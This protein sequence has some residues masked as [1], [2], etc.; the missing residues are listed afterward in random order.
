MD[1][2]INRAAIRYADVDEAVAVAHIRIVVNG[3][4]GS[5]LDEVIEPAAVRVSGRQGRLNVGETQT[6]VAA[7]RGDTPPPGYISNKYVDQWER[8]R[9][10]LEL[11]LAA[12]AEEIRDQRE[13]RLDAKRD[14]EAARLQGTLT[15]LKTSI[16]RRLEDL[17]SSPDTE[18]LRLFDAEERE[19][20]EADVAA[21]R[22]RIDQIDDDI[23]TEIKNLE[24]RYRVRDIHW[25]PVAIE[26]VV[27]LGEV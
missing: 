2:S 26:V 1:R 11:A 15:D 13:R 18:Q 12:R 10:A 4:D 21:L 24:E 9:P 17:E 19:Q 7:G 23:A 25:F 3:A 6:V 5:T 8:V 16:Q 22:R 14:R 27:P 20:F